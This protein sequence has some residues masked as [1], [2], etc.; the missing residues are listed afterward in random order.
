[1]ALAGRACLEI[2]EIDEDV[3][4]DGNHDCDDSEV[5]GLPLALMS[6]V[7]LEVLPQDLIRLGSGADGG[8]VLSAR[9]RQRHL[10]VLRIRE[11][12]AR[13]KRVKGELSCGKD[14]LWCWQWSDVCDDRPMMN[15]R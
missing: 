3:G 5:D 12:R 4:G 10:V 14:L 1:M 9:V 13:V 8:V 6:L 7:E 15:D 11:T 2:A